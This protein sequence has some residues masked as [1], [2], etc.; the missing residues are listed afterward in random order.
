MRVLPRK[1]DVPYWVYL[2]L[3]DL[4]VACS[5]SRCMK[6][7]GAFLI[8][9]GLFQVSLQRYLEPSEGFQIISGPFWV[10]L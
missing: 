4:V 8:I 10:A 2:G 1:S 3:V 9:R 5:I 7:D 6:L